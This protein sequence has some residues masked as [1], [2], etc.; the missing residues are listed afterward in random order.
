MRE[1]EEQDQDLPVEV[2]DTVVLAAQLGVEARQHMAQVVKP[3]QARWH[4]A[5]SDTR[6]ELVGGDGGEAAV[7]RVYVELGDSAGERLESPPAYIREI[8]QNRNSMQTLPKNIT[9]CIADLRTAISA[10]S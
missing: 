8:A 9:K 1:S 5:V 6:E 3:A 4:V 2:L 10:E 7:G